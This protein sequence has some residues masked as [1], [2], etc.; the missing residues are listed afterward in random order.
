MDANPKLGKRRHFHVSVLSDRGSYPRMNVHRG[1][2]VYFASESLVYT[3]VPYE[4]PNEFGYSEIT[5]AH[6]GE[7]RFWGAVA[8]SITEG[9]GFYHFHPLALGNVYAENVDTA[10]AERVARK[11]AAEHPEQ[12]HKLHWVAC[13][14]D[15]VMRLYD[16][17]QS[18]SPTLLRGVSCYLKAHMLGKY[19]FFD[20]EMGINLYITLEA[21][22]ATI[23]RRLSAPAGRDVSYNDVFD[24]VRANLT[25]GDALADYWQDAHDDRNALLHP[26]NDFSPYAIQPMSADDI[27]ELFDPMLSLYRYILLGEP[28]PTYEEITGRPLDK[29]ADAAKEVC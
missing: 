21:G 3:V 22:L 24:H 11:V 16:V 23:R 2:A 20:E 4:E 13:N 8:F 5:W 29:A 19:E 17:L 7:I 28:R 12:S 27:V 9:R 26:D 10:L 25:F 6:L 1:D 14:Q 15:E 18:A